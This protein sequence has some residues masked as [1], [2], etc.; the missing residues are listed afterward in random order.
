MVGKGGGGGRG[1]NGGRGAGRGG[2]G[3]SK[4]WSERDGLA[5]KFDRYLGNRRQCGEKIKPGNEEIL[6]S[7]SRLVYFEIFFPRFSLSD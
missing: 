4:W 6:L 3:G 5:V 1:I 2:G 7:F